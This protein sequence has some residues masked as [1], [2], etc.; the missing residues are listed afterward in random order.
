MSFRPQGRNL[1]VICFPQKKTRHDASLQGISEPDEIAQGADFGAVSVDALPQVDVF[2]KGNLL[3]V[4]E[5][6]DDVIR[7]VFGREAVLFEGLARPDLEAAFGL[8]ITTSYSNHFFKISLFLPADSFIVFCN[9]AISVSIFS[10]L[11]TM[12][13]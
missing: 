9:A 12:A 10:I 2:G 5:K 11:E 7:S 3:A 1:I 6:E 13:C 8:N 4:V